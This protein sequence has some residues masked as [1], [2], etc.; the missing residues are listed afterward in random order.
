MDSDFY[1]SLDQMDEEQVAAIVLVL[2]R[3]PDAV[4][5]GGPLDMQAYLF[6]LRHGLLDGGP[7]GRVSEA[8]E[9]FLA[10]FERG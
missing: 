6:A 10:L 8:G 4:S 7:P 2:R 9:A 1:T 5:D 3:I